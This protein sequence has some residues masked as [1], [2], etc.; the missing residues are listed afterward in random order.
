MTKKNTH[1]KRR[2]N[3]LA[4][5][6]AIVFSLFLLITF[7]FFKAFVSQSRQNILLQV[8]FLDA[9][10]ISNDFRDEL[11]QY[12]ISSNPRWCFSPQGSYLVGPTVFSLYSGLPLEKTV[13]KKRVIAFSNDEDYFIVFT[14]AK[15]IAMS[16][17]SGIQIASVGL[18][19]WRSSQLLGDYRTIFDNTAFYDLF[20]GKMTDE[21]K[22]EQN[23]RKIDN[24]VPRPETSDILTKQWINKNTRECILYSADGSV[25]HRYFGKF[26]RNMTF[27]PDG[28]LLSINTYENNSL[29]LSGPVLVYEVET[30]KEIGKYGRIND[31]CS[32]AVSHNNKIL[33]MATHNNIRCYD[34]S[35]SKIIWQKPVWPASIEL[36]SFTKDDTHFL[37][38]GLSEPIVQMWETTTCQEKFRL[39]Y[40]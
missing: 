20:E 27:S 29:Q 34:I 33:L 13:M 9:G 17:A 15:C 30:G 8:K 1:Y 40:D 28:S 10:T 37:T 23:K 25:L 5:F 35:T 6:L 24:I 3:S 16:S 18:K 7:P 32:L 36:C 4:S 26:G 12:A 11:G 21:W 14:G 2:R 19:N 39:Y 22:P 31:D 38:C